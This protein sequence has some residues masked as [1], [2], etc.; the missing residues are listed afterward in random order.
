MERLECLLLTAQSV[1]P[2]WAD[3]IVQIQPAMA[4]RIRLM[5]KNQVSNQVG[6]AVR[7]VVQAGLL[8]SNNK[9]GCARKM[10]GEKKR[11]ERKKRLASGT[12]YINL[13]QR[14]P[15]TQAAAVS[16]EEEVADGVVNC[17]LRD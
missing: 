16:K 17:G 10:K 6:Q 5:L 1:T 7:K 9:L 2:T 14:R 8:N 4:T 11:K 3:T 13:I 12:I 15:L